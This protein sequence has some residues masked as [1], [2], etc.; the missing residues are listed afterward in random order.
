LNPLE[1]N[2]VQVVVHTCGEDGILLSGLIKKIVAIDVECTKNNFHVMFRESQRQV[3]KVIW[4]HPP[5]RGGGGIGESALFQVIVSVRLNK[6]TKSPTGLRD[7]TVE[8]HDERG[9][10]KRVS[11]LFFVIFN[12][13]RVE[14][15]RMGHLNSERELSDFKRVRRA[16][17]QLDERPDR[18]KAPAISFA[19]NSSEVLL[20]ERI[21]RG[22]N[23]GVV[24][25]RRGRSRVRRSF[26]DETGGGGWIPMNKKQLPDPEVLS[27]GK[28]RPPTRGEKFVR[29]PVAIYIPGNRT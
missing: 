12:D 25:F 7:R 15:R 27:S 6:K 17:K 18:G 29:E 24:R 11:E 19:A 28:T 1:A 22:Q 3:A 16:K 5:I 21:Q 26:M 13:I 10:G 8:E 14:M 20:V 4:S 2:H 9:G 23:L